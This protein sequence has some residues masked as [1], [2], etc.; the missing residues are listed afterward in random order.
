ME[1]RI[2]M[3]TLGVDD[4]SATRRFFE[5][6]LGWKAAG[7]DS[8]EIVFYDT[9]ETIL[10]IYGRTALADDAGVAADP[11]GFPATALAW[12]GRTKAEVDAAFAKAV[13]AGGEAIKEPQDVFWGGYSGYVGIPGG[14]LMEIAYNP[15]FLLD[16]SGK[17]L[18]PAP[19][20]S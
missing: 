15:A 10:G 9:G 14:H 16:E 1:Q 4:I 3:V 8:E 11:F 20:D 18:L 7:F 13:A 17:M 6:G 12:N 19:K 5:D 2:T